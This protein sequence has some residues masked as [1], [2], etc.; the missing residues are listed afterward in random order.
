MSANE[1]QTYQPAANSLPDKMAFAKALAAAGMIPKVYQAA[2][3]NVLVAIELGEALGIAPIVA[4][5]EI[6]VINGTPSPSASLMV[7]LARAAGHKVRVW[8]DDNGAG[9][10]EIIRADDPEFTHRSVWDEKKARTAGLWGKGHW[11][12]DSAT[13]LRWRAASE[14]VRLACSEVLGGLK[15]TPEEMHEIAGVPVGAPS[16]VRSESASVSSLS[17]RLEAQP[18]ETVEEPDYDALEAHVAETTDLEELRRVWKAMAGVG[19]ER[20]GQVQDL[21]VARKAALEAEPAPEP[22]S[23]EQ[24]TLDA[25]VVG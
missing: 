17:D 13:M 15:Y 7:S 23:D 11:A 22:E 10:C 16:P 12:K 25:E 4:I 5:N 14:C 8:N 6:N 1:I 21:V 20:A 18:A 3:A 24:P 19:T 9:V 2:P